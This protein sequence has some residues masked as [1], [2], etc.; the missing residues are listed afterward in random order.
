MS[1]DRQPG[2]EEQL[3]ASEPFTVPRA[4]RVHF[5]RR[6]WFRY[7]AAIILLAGAT[8]AIVVSSDRRSA[9][10]GTDLSKRFKNDV[11]PGGNKATLTLADG[12][13]IV[14][15]ST[16]NGTIA[17]QGGSS[18][19]KLSNGQIRYDLKGLSQ[20]SVSWNTLSTPRGGTYQITLPD[21]SKVWLNAESSITYPV[22]FTGNERRVELVDGEAYFEVAKDSKRPFIVSVDDNM[23]VEVLGTHFNVNAYEDEEVI[24]TTLVEGKVKVNKSNK[25]NESLLLIPGQQAKVN[26]ENETITVINDVDTEEAIAW[27]EG[28]F[29]FEDDDIKTVMRQLARWYDVEVEYEGKVPDSKP[30]LY[31]QLYKRI[32]I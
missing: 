28:L 31:W 17:T 4:H 8:I 24:K 18:I 19:I 13:T 21:G 29:Y 22:A 25:S 11:A 30:I 7:A 15:D 2:A 27:K 32:H 12:R 9:K 10:S 5:L 3:I 20:G 26:I 1:S 6:A 16:Q 14:L 23:E